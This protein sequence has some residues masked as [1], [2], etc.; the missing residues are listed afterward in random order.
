MMNTPKSLT[1]TIHVRFHYKEPEL[2]KATEGETKVL[3]ELL[4]RVSELAPEHQDLL[5]KFANYLKDFSGN[6][7]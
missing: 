7:K 4:A 6:G 5:V 3:D 2:E 1:A